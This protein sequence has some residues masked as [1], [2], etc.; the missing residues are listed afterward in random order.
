MARSSD[1]PPP[2]PTEVTEPLPAVGE[3]YGYVE[4]PP[5]EEEV[6]EEAPPRRPPVLWPYLLAL[7]LLVLAGLAALWYFTREDEPDRVPVPGVVRLREGDAVQRLR[8]EGLRV[9]IER[10]RSDEA[11]QGVVFAQRPGAGRDVEEDSTVTILVSSGPASAEVPEVTGLP[12]DRAE[13]LLADEGF[14]LR[15]AAV[16]SEKPP[17]TVVAQDPAAGEK[18]P[19]DSPVRINV[20]RG[21]GRVQ[22]PDVVGRT[23]AEAGAILRRAGLATPNVVSVPSDRPANEVIAQNPPAGT[24]VKKETRVRINVS[25]GK[26]GAGSGT[27]TAP[28]GTPLPDV[29]GQTE[30]EAVQALEDAGA[31]VRVTSEDVT[32][33][34]E[35]GVVLRQNPAAGE[36]VQPGDEVEIVVGRATQ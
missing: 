6:V 28:A 20:S 10:R 30:D 24:E 2:R 7:L 29:V 23:A 5:V 9:Q 26:G 8:D 3:R 33:P 16:F 12:A 17:G 25:N 11:T 15:R 14:T 32:D 36:P 13:Q 22:V 19:L 21:T 27:T 34:G 35:D 1:D 4:E 31:S 18:A